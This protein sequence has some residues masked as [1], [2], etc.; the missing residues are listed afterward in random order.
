MFG[1]IMS[2]NDELIPRYFWLCAD[3]SAEDVAAALVLGCRGILVS[4]A[5]ANSQNPEGF[6][7]EIGG[8]I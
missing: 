5:V 1:K 4:S 8:L 6:L 3:A 2:L 7:K